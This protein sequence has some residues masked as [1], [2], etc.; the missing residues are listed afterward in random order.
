MSFDVM[1]L[2]VR[3]CMTPP[4]YLVPLP[5]DLRQ[6]PA[7]DPIWLL[8]LPLPHVSASFTDLFGLFSLTSQARCFSAQLY[9]LTWGFFVLNMLPVN[10]DAITVVLVMLQTTFLLL[11]VL[12]V[13]TLM[14]RK[15]QLMNTVHCA[16]LHVPVSSCSIYSFHSHVFWYN[17]G[18][19]WW[20]R[21]NAWASFAQHVLCWSI[22][23]LSVNLW[24]SCCVLC[25]QD[26]AMIRVWFRAGLIQKSL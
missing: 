1:L 20:E 15:P 26:K 3:V 25:W 6:K 9:L 14:W 5:Q 7:Q 24:L 22:T 4:C 8:L 11:V 17:R 23:V 18:E 16:S 13:V 19:R 2:L 21:F 12:P 10:T